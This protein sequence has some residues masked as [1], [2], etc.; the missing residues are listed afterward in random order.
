VPIKTIVV[1][2]N[3]SYTN[4]YC[5][6]DCN[7]LDYDDDYCK[8]FLQDI[9]YIDHKD[10]IDDYHPNKRCDKCKEARIII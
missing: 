8:L 9:R 5:H 7:Y 10:R 4:E 6:E 3:I 1:K 2:T